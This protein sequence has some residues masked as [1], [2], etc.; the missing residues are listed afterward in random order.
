MLIKTI[1]RN[2]SKSLYCWGHNK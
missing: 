2:I 1:R